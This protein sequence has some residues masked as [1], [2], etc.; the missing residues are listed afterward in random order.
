MKALSVRQPWANRIAD[1]SKRIEYRSWRTSYRGPLLIVAS[2]RPDS[3]AVDHPGPFGGSVCVVDLISITGH[4]GAY[5]WHVDNPRRVPFIPIR[6]QLGLYDVPDIGNDRQ[7]SDA[8]Y[9]RALSVPI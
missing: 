2:A 1:G 6:G 5:E 7:Y 3:S 4:P 8:I 9:Q